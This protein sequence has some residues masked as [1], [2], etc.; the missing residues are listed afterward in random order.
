MKLWK[1]GIL[2]T[3]A[4]LLAA[5]MKAGCGGEKLEASSASG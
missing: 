1:K 4:L 5:G 3:S 2:I